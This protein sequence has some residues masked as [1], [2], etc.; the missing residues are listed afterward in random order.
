MTMA[1]PNLRINRVGYYYKRFLLRRHTPHLKKT[2]MTLCSICKRCAKRQTVVVHKAPP[3]HRRMRNQPES[4]RLRERKESCLR[5]HRIMWPRSHRLIPSRGYGATRPMPW[6]KRS[7][8][9]ISSP[10]MRTW[11]TNYRNAA[12]SAITV[13]RRLTRVQMGLNC[14]PTCATPLC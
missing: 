8:H 5:D 9:L 11:I 1:R 10:W 3:R 12:C 7:R 13:I 14:L 2:K 4:R 6:R